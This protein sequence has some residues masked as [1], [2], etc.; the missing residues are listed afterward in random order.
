MKYKQLILE[1]IEYLENRI[2]TL[3]SQNGSHRTTFEEVRETEDSISETIGDIK[4]LINSNF[5]E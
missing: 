5:E 3:R 4:T 1:K 2:K